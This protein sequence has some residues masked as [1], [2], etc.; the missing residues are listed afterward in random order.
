VEPRLVAP[1]FSGSGGCVRLSAG[2]SVTYPPGSQ[3][4]YLDHQAFGRVAL[5]RV[6]KVGFAHPWTLHVV[7]AAGEIVGLPTGVLLRCERDFFGAT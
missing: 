2:H 3:V 4:N 1:T 5:I 6:P 7:A